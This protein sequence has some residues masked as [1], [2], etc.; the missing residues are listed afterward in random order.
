M[1]AAVEEKTVEA[2][3]SGL[4]ATDASRRVGWAKAFEALARVDALEE[5]L[6]QTR[7]ELK[8]LRRAYSRLLGFVNHLPMLRSPILDAELSTHTQ[9]EKTFRA[10]DAW[11]SGAALAF[12]HA[13]HIGGGDEVQVRAER[14]A[15]K[16]AKRRRVGDLF[17]AAADAGHDSKGSTGLWLCTCGA[18]STDDGEDRLEHLAQ[19]IH[20]TSWKSLQRRWSKLDANEPEDGAA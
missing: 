2:L 8:Y 18:S 3:A 20:G 16:T 10:M 9:A 13:L 12:K 6:R 19:V 4:N 14:A 11:D 7:D 17:R 1:T 5:Q 15:K